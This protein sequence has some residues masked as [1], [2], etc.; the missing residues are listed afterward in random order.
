MFKCVKISLVKLSL[1]REFKTLRQFYFTC[2]KL[3][4][5]FSSKSDSKTLQYEVLPANC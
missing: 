4:D 5:L 1:Q 2:F 3:L